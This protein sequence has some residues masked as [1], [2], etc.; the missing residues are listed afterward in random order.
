MSIVLADTFKMGIDGIVI[1][2]IVSCLS[3]N[4]WWD[5][6]VVYKYALKANL[7]K[8]FSK[9]ILYTLVL[10]GCISLVLLIEIWIPVNIFTFFAYCIISVFIPV[11]IIILLFR[12]TDNFEYFKNIAVSKIKKRK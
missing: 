3:T 2:T 9:Y 10:V 7:S 1:G 4:L 6:Y 5:P 11:M 12:K 8:Y